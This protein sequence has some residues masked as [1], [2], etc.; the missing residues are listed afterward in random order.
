MNRRLAT[1]VI[2]ALVAAAAVNW[3]WSTAAF[4]TA[5]SVSV[6]ASTSPLSDDSLNISGG[7]GQSAT[8]GIAVSTAP[9]VLVTDAKGNPVSGVAVTFAVASGSGSITGPTAATNSSGIATVGSWT[10]GTTAGSNTLTATGTGVTG[11]PV[12][13]T[14][15]GVAG[16]AA[17]MS[18]YAGNGQ[19][20]T[21]NT[22]ITTAPAVLVTDANNNP[23]A[24][25]NV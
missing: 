18:L 12:T 25:T 7:N 20:A 17:K 3:S 13:F 19:S 2:L 1:L 16:I 9:A 4:T 5:S 8:A 11:S 21:V 14:A 10:L 23:V 6:Q 22:A 24:G 15:T